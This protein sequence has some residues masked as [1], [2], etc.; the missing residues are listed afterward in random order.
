MIWYG[1]LQNCKTLNTIFN[2]VFILVFICVYPLFFFVQLIQI[3]RIMFYQ[4]RRVFYNN[5]LDN[6][7]LMLVPGP[8]CHVKKGRPTWY[9]SNPH[10]TLSR[11][12]FLICYTFI[13]SKERWVVYLL[14]Y[15]APKKNTKISFIVCPVV[16]CF[17]AT[18]II[19]FQVRRI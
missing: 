2:I 11:V 10:E 17:Y 8:N 19:R 6:Y 15:V 5:R 4:C 1:L 12:Y 16:I 13:S 14:I 9:S 7:K 3:R 18:V